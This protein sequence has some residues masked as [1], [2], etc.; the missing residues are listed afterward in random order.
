MGGPA[1][2]YLPGFS[3]IQR[4]CNSRALMTAISSNWAIRTFD[5]SEICSTRDLR[6][7]NSLGTVPTPRA[8]RT[9][10]SR[11][12]Q[13]LHQPL[14]TFGENRITEAAMKLSNQNNR[15]RKRNGRRLPDPI[16]IRYS[17]TIATHAIL[18]S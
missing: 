3:I 8:P 16:S 18:N 15:Y 4:A 11:P 17:G 6:W 9:N 12:L 14:L 7:A 5:G 13:T 1:V 2:H 10:P